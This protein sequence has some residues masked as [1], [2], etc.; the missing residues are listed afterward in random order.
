MAAWLEGKQKV[1]QLPASKSDERFSNRTIV[2]AA[3]V[4]HD[5]LGNK[6]AG[7]LQ[8]QREFQEND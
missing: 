5:W 7:Y 2:Y 8:D 6:R 3:T 4:A 1:L